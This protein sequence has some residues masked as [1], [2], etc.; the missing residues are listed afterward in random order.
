MAMWE[1]VVAQSTLPPFL[2]WVTDDAIKEA[3][4]EGLDRAIFPDRS[5]PQPVKR[6]ERARAAQLLVPPCGF[7]ALQARS[8]RRAAPK[9]AE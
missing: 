6:L 7:E 4:H 3:A 2:V 8:S 9:A 5:A 1:R